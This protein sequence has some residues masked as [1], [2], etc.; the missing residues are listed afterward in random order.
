[1]NKLTHW[2][3]C[4]FLLVSQVNYTQT[5]FA[6]HSE[7]LSHDRINRFMRENKLTP[8]ELR[9]LVRQELV[10]SENGYL[11]FDDTVLDKSHSSPLNWCAGNG[12]AMQ[13]RLSK[14]SAS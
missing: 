1:M 5:Y 6:D 12:V 14:E 4:Q 2:D 10:L 7:Q 11:L 3:Y 13:R 9:Q 8:H